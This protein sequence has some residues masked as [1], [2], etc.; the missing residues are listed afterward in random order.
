MLIGDPLTKK[1]VVICAKSQII[2]NL[3]P[4]VFVEQVLLGQ[5][6]S[7]AEGLFE[8]LLLRS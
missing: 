4:L 6:H 1:G 5:V 2:H 8:D 7:R 3:F